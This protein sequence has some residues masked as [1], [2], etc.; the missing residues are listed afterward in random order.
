ML[1][2]LLAACLTLAPLPVQA[3]DFGFADFEIYKFAEGARG[4]VAA[5]VSGDGVDDLA[6]IN[7][8]RSR[9]E[10]LVRLGPDDPDSPAPGF[11][12]SES[13]AL[14]Y[15]ER[16]RHLP[17][18]VERRVWR[19]ALGDLDGDGIGELVFAAEGGRLSVVSHLAGERVT[20]TRDLDGLRSGCRLLRVVDLDGD[21]AREI[22]AVGADEVLALGLEA[23]GA[24]GTPRVV[25][26]LDGTPD[27]LHTFDLD[28]DGR[29][30]LVYAYHGQDRPFR[31]R[32]GQ[33]G[34]AFEPRVD[35]HLPQV[36][37]SASADLG[38][39]GGEVLLAVFKLSG[40]LAFLHGQAADGAE[41]LL[42]R[43]TLGAAAGRGKTTFGLG[44]LNAD[45]ATDLAVAFDEGARLTLFYG[46]PGSRAPRRVEV[47]SLVGARDPRIAD[48]DGDG[49]AELLVCSE[50]ERMVG[51]SSLDGDGRLPF[52]RGVPLDAAPVAMDLADVDG[53][54]RP[55]VVLLTSQGEG[56]RREIA[57]TV[58][59]AGEEGLE[60]EPLLVLPLPQ[61]KKVPT[62]LR[63]V[64]LDGDGRIDLVV[65]LPGNDEAPL[66]LV[67]RDGGFVADPRGGDVPGLGV[68]AGAGPERLFV[69]D[70]D[71]RPGDELLVSAQGFARTLSLEVDGERFTTRVG[72][73][74][75]G[76]TAEA[77]IAGCAAANLDGG[78]RP[79]LVLRDA[80]AGE[81]QVFDLGAEGSLELRHRLRSGAG[82]RGLLAADLDADGRQEVVLLDDRGFSVLH[83]GAA[84]V[85]LTETASYEPPKES[86]F[87]DRVVAGDLN[88]DGRADV[89]VT[90]TSE[91]ALILLD[92]DPPGLRRALGF[93][94]FETKTFG[95][96]SESREPRELL[97]AELT[98]DGKDD[99]AVLVH[100]KLIL[101]VQ[102]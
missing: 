54:A 77:S 46:V 26:H 48:L 65:F 70:V 60:P 63:A 39:A 7:E 2:T 90:E 75:D 13:N 29:L 30:D 34:G 41:P 84:A 83:P 100:D 40:R 96:G 56:R 52:P 91:H 6:L 10:V 68:L 31:W 66:L 19:M 97:C 51:V 15:D 23:D 86:V 92:A 36:R 9:I 102:E 55:D 58:L 49:R 95:M 82:S 80:H 5:D 38:P 20:R 78:P 17:V 71:G 33:V 101:Y 72:E 25:D 69:G 27:D 4:L 32:R 12:P 62:A 81:V 37:S 64:E 89:A 44:D 1:P 67:Q 47:P 99:L 50:S 3:E 24:L 35:L 43:H 94:V 21:G 16:Y 87:L 76:T 18:A 42:A 59:S 98:G 79:A 57:L 93:R 22:L 45:G 28:G 61:V 14:R 85:H 88:A 8:A 73:Q 11:D 53:D 74:F